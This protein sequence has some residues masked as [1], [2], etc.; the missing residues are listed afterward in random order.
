MVA[1][2]AVVGQDEAGRATG[3]PHPLLGEQRPEPPDDPDGVTDF[4]RAIGKQVKLLRE[5]AGLTQKE[6]GDRLRYG[7]DQIS[8]LE[9]GRRTP[10]PEFLDA[11]DELLGAGGL[12]KAAKEDL[13]R[14]KA[15]ARVRHP[16]WF[17]DYARL[18]A[19]AVELHFYSSHDIPGL[20][21]TEARARALYA[22]RKP[23]LAEE[24]IEERVL[25]RLARQEILTRW[26]TPIV[27]CI[28]EESVLRRP[29]GGWA[30]H[31]EQLRQL[32]RLGGLRS[33]ELQVMPLE[34]HE[35][36]G[37]GGPFI[38]LTPKGRPQVAYVEVQAVSRLT[39][40]AEEVR[41]LAARYGSLRAQAM[42]PPESLALIE[43]ML[44]E[45]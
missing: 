3:I 32:L 9:R 17:R 13:A 14:A 33:M 41:I 45:R 5:R 16:A 15:K 44:G 34:R 24:V 39:T 22:M 40:D 12:L 2:M 36:A 35:H 7:E 26:P 27:S 42:T 10:Q 1:T 38:L 19:E 43:K 21:Q 28:I 18:E 8:S 6:L 30:V 4:L 23:L 25:A 29:L 20:L 11:A 31:D 37:M